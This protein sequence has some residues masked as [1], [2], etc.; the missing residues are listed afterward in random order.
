MRLLTPTEMRK[1]KRAE[2]TKDL[3]LSQ[4]VSRVS[5]EKRQELN[6]IK[7]NYDTQVDKM[8]AEFS[9]RLDEHNTRIN[10]LDN[11]VATLESRRES[12]LKPITLIEQET[13][14]KNEEADNRTLELDSIE[15]QLLIQESN[16]SQREQTVGSKEETLNSL[17]E[18]L[19]LEKKNVSEGFKEVL[20]QKQEL[21]NEKVEHVAK[22]L[23]EHNDIDGLRGIIVTDRQTL[24]S[25][26]LAVELRERTV[27][28]EWIKINDQRATLERAFN[29]IKK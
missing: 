9:V 16:L 13:D 11:E 26:K 19:D 6:D 12:A 24:N 4:K 5:K 10:K 7:T 28:K 2:L 3:V 18:T 8:D 27:D 20:E 25:T 22:I 1:E 14:R 29:R 23:K 15:E 17:Q 21:A